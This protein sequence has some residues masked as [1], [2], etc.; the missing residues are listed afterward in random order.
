MLN[1][2]SK[3]EKRQIRS[4][5]RI[6]LNIKN[7]INRLRLSEVDFWR[8]LGVEIGKDVQMYNCD[9]D[10][11]FAYLLKIGDGSVLSKV[12]VLT[13]DASMRKDINAVK[14]GAV[15]IGKNCFIGFDTLIMPGVTIGDNSVVAARSLVNKDVPPNVVVGGSPA[16]VIKTLEEYHDKIKIDIKNNP[17]FMHP[18]FYHTSKDEVIDTLSETKIGYSTTSEDFFDRNSEKI[19]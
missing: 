6:F 19:K 1:L 7:K 12:S 10:R 4:I 14:I 3:K 16:R 8:Y 5:D 2:K 9:I 17:L 13:H 18:D 15:E 11:G